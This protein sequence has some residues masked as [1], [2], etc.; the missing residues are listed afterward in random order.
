MPALR[1]Q[2]LKRLWPS[3]LHDPVTLTPVH[4]F[5]AL[6]L[7]LLAELTLQGDSGSDDNKR[8]TRFLRLAQTVASFAATKAATAD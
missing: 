1:F 7:P 3:L 5:A 6:Q 8:P 4:F 2:S